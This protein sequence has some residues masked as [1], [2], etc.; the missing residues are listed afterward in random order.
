MSQFAALCDSSETTSTSHKQ[1]KTRVKSRN[2]L[3]FKGRE[4]CL[5]V[6]LFASDIGIKRYRLLKQQYGTSGIKPHTHG[7]AGKPAKHWLRYF[8]QT[9]NRF[10]YSSSIIKNSLDSYFRA[11]FLD[12]RPRISFCCHQ[13]SLNENCTENYVT[14]CDAKNIQAVGYDSFRRVWKD[15]LPNTVIQ[16]WASHIKDMTWIF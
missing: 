3:M 14:A 12:S 10:C 16:K 2:S 1:N 11:A 9:V 5:P 7:N 8:M 15:A 13:V 6:F 4:V